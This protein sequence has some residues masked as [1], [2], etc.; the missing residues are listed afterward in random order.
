M[1]ARSARPRRAPSS[2]AHRPRRSDDHAFE[3]P[4]ER[5]QLPTIAI[6]QIAPNSAARPQHHGDGDDAENDEIDA[7]VIGEEFAQDE[8]DDRADD[9]SL[10]APDAADDRDED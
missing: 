7:A 9:R 1:T 8:E 4:G 6:G 10:D 5:K 2:S 3:P